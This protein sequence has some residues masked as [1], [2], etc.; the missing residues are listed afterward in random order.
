MTYKAISRPSF[1]MLIPFLFFFYLIYA[2]KAERNGK[3]RK[4][5][6]VSSL[7][8]QKKRSR[9]RERERKKETGALLH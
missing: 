2:G 4:K 1:T 7:N 3:Q 9:E 8:R 6:Q 5:K